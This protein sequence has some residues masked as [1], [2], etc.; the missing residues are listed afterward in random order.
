[1]LEQ[2]EAFLV[3]D[4]RDALPNN[5]RLY[6]GPFEPSSGQNIIIHT[7]RLELEPIVEGED[8]DGGYL[9]QEV[10]WATDGALKSFDMPETM[11]GEVLE[12]QSPPGVRRELGEHLYVE[13]QTLHFYVAPAAATPGVRA[14]IRDADAAGWKRRR[15]CLITLEIISWAPDIEDTDANQATALNTALSSMVHLPIFE[16]PRTPGKDIHLRLLTSRVTLVKFV[17]ERHPNQNLYGSYTV[18]ELQAKL[19]VLVASGAPLPEY[20][21]DVVAQSVALK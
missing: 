11:P 6:T 14:R 2:L 21:I 15:N 17:R 18:I 4:I 7:R 19:D 3:D 16:F 5:V 13:G 1:M 9:I 12:I 8:D 20:L 10:E